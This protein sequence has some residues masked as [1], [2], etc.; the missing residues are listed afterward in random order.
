MQYDTRKVEG[1]LL[2]KGFQMDNSHHHMFTYH[3]ADGR[4]SMVRTRTS[5][6]SKTISDSLI[7]QM[8]RQC[9]LAKTQFIDLIDCP[10]S[11]ESYER[12]LNGQDALPQ[13][14]S[15]SDE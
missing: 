1:A 10:L 8:A 3:T 13:R 5:H 14:L 12:I 9:R 6:G 4:R 15:A 7:A 11:R 2:K